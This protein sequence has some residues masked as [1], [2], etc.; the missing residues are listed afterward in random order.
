MRWNISLA[1]LA[2]LLGCASEGSAADTAVVRD[3]ETGFTFSEFQAAFVIGQS[4]KFRVAVPSPAPD[5]FDLV[6]QIVAPVSV[7]WTGLAWGASMVND[8]L[9]IGWASGTTP[10]LSVRRTTVRTQPQVYDGAKVQI[11]KTGSKVNGTH[12]QITAKCSGCSSFSTTGSNTKSLNPTG[13]NRLAFAYSKTKPNS[14][15]AAAMISVHDV[16]SYWDHD[17]SAAGNL[18]F[19]QLVTKNT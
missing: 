3:G 12:W 1:Y 16:Y 8:P 17:F 7:G 4:I 18:D 5:K 19:D 10:V 14:A 2:A 6:F 15:S 13:V 9:T 11:L